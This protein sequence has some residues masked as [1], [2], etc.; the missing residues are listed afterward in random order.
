MSSLLL[1]M[2]V[3][4]SRSQDTTMYLTY[5]YQEE[6]ESGVV[7]AD[8][9]ER[10][11]E[12]GL[13]SPMVFQLLPQETQHGDKLLLK[14][15]GELLS[16]SLLDRD[17]LCGAEEQCELRLDVSVSDSNHRYVVVIVLVELEDVN[18]NKPVYETK[19]V[20]LIIPESAPV[21]SRWI[22]PQASDRDIGDNGIIQYQLNATNE[23]F[24]ITIRQPTLFLELTAPLDYETKKSFRLFVVAT[25]LT[26]SRSS[27]FKQDTQEVNIVI[28]D[29]NDNTPS[30]T[31]DSY[32][33]GIDEDTEEHKVVLQVTALDIDQGENSEIRYSL[34]PDDSPFIIHESTG[35]VS[36]YEELDHEKITRYDLSVVATDQGLESIPTSTELVIHVLDINDNPPVITFDTGSGADSAEVSVVENDSS[37]LST[38]TSLGHLYITDD[39]SGVNAEV[40]C[41]LDGDI[42]RLKKLYTNI[43]ELLLVDVLDYEKQS[44]HDVTSRCNDSANP[45]MPSEKII[46]VFVE[47]LND[48]NPKCDQD[49]YHTSVH[50]GK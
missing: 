17:S 14:E 33:I 9:N 36:L 1:L 25:D 12:Q 41:H 47:D 34:Q 2:I 8:L 18:D 11:T 32:E 3:S 23:F 13:V 43:Y 49:V 16:A 5:T 44:V 30:F 50:E 31:E 46:R 24:K 38:E 15:S 22:L 21:K 27:E 40:N 26:S 20:D 37:G 29:T 19:H 39:D 4:A 28:R 6:V 7:L 42:F 35:K 45:V 10:L 48:N